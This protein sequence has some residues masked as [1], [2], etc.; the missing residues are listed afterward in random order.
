MEFNGI[1]NID[2]PEGITSHTAVSRVRRLLGVKKAGH[3]GTLDPLATGVLPIMVGTAVKVSDWLTGHNKGYLAGIRLGIET[4]SEDITGKVIAAYN[5]TLPSFDDF[6]RAAES[7]VGKVQQIPPMYSAIKKDGRKLVDLAR[8]GVTIERS[9]R[10]IE[11][12][13]INAIQDGTELFLEV[14]C[15]KGTYIRTLCADIGKCL[16]C[17]AV[18]SSL[19]RTKVGNFTAAASI[20]LDTLLN[21][22]TEDIHGLIMPAES[23]FSDMEIVTLPPFFERLFKNGAPVFVHKLGRSDIIEGVLYRIYGSEGFFALG[24]AA[25]IDG[26]DAI[27]VKKFF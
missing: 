27:K 7:F 22:S 6:K 14:A 12:Y 25:V 3:S 13:S 2:K 26:L 24:E 5:G 19:R 23:I 17:G 10:E 18:M 11:I 15:S 9:P 20:P 8:K 21:M 4:D 16:G 1:L